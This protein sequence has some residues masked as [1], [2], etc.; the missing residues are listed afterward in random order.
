MRSLL[1]LFR[2]PDRHAELDDE[3]RAHLA[4]AIA[5]RVNRGESPE[6]ADAAARREFGNVTTV[7]EVTREMWGGASF[8]RLVHDVRYGVRTL[9]RSPGFLAVALISLGLGIGA[10][11]AAFSLADAALFR[12]LAIDDPDR[13]VV[14][15]ART[16]RAAV[17]NLSYPELRDLQSSTRSFSGLVAARTSRMAIA[18]ATDPVPQMRFALLV[19]DGFFDVLG[20]PA[21]VGRRF[22]PHEARTRGREPV[23]MLSHEYWQ[24][25]FGGDPAV[26]G[27]TVRIN[28]RPFTVVG[29]LPATFTGLNQF[30]RPSLFIPMTAM[31][32]AGTPSFFDRRDEFALMVRGRLRPGVTIDQAQAELEVFARALARD[33]PEINR[34]R[35]LAAMSEFRARVADAPPTLAI[36]GLLLLLAALVL[37]IACANVA[38]LQLG[39]ARARSREMAVRLAIGAGRLRLVRQLMTESLLVAGAGG[40]AGVVA[41]YGAIGL[42]GAMQLPTDTPLGLAV[43]LD[44]RVLVAGVGASMAA[45]CLFGLVPAWKTAGANLVGALKSQDLLPGRSRLLGRNLLVVSQIAICAVL[46]VVSSALVDAFRRVEAADP[47]LRAMQVMMFEF[48]PVLVGYDQARATQFYRLLVDRARQVPG[49]R[50]ATL[51]SAIPFRPNYSDEE[52]VPEGYQFAGH[53]RS[54][55]VPVNIIDDQHFATMGTPLVAGRAFTTADTAETPAVAI[56]NEELAA[57]YWPGRS[58]IAQR[59]FVGP[60]RRPVE[61]VGV[62]QTGKYGSL[63]EAPQP[64]LYLPLAQR[65]RTRLLLLAASDGPPLALTSPVLDAVRSLDPNQPVFNVRDFRTYYEQGALGPPRVLTQMAGAAGIAGL[66][67]ALVGVYGLVNYS[68]S[69]RTREFG[70]RM[71]IGASRG[72]VLR[73]VL[74]QGFVLALVGALLGVALSAPVFLAISAGMSGLGAL[75]RWTLVAVPLGLVGVAVAACWAPARRATRISPTIALRTE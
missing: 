23:V 67:L 68:V 58:P 11:T 40:L 3:I 16:P 10:N 41:A 69:R 37:F 14:V 33:Y 17:G 72:A 52:I 39:R 20:V 13:V 31:D 56:I 73:L 30:L 42:L 4:L 62:A 22:L 18:R 32:T 26:I 74:T 65:P 21:A 6:Q 25:H 7:A 61:I 50:S 66:C 51:A 12:P 45:A 8:E 38:S 35:G 27:A 19:S 46:L 34:D 59:F 9:R 48:D 75:S 70:I 47:G 43:Q 5:D 57:R 71:A 36:V 28:A 15:A 60:E 54:V 64:Y 49:V 2:R 24:S 29:V 53:E 55:R 1:R 63:T 44:V